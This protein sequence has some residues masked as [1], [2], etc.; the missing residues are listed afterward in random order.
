[1]PD[2]GGSW[3]GFLR[4]WTCWIVALRWVDVGMRVAD[5]MGEIWWWVLDRVSG[6]V[7]EEAGGGER[8]EEVVLVYLNVGGYCWI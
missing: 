6:V 8:V 7:E 1:M 2:P 4:E 3:S 5:L